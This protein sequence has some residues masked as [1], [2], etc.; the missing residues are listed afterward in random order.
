MS[1]LESFTL[2]FET[3]GL[4]NVSKETKKLK[5]DLNNL[6]T[7]EKSLQE[8]IK[9]GG[10]EA[11]EAKIRL[12]KVQTE[13]KNVKKALKGEKKEIAGTEKAVKKLG[14]TVEKEGIRNV[15]ALAVQLLRSVSPMLFFG[16]A[17]SGAMQFVS[18]AN[19]IA[20][21][22]K[23]AGLSMEE[24]QKKNGDKY[25]IFT[26]DDV[27]IAREYEMTMRDVRMGTKSIGAE[28][29]RMILPSL[30]KL[31][32]VVSQVVDYFTKHATFIKLL[33]LGIAAAITVAAIPA[34]ISMGTALWTALAP[35]IAP[36]L[37]V[38]AV[39]SAIALVI[40][41]LIVWING[42][43][44]AFADLWAEVFGD[45]QQAKKVF[46]DL[47]RTIKELWDT[48]A[49]ILKS[50][51]EFIL[52]FIFTSI[53]Q[54]ISA[55]KDFVNVVKSFKA[56]DILGGFKNIGAGLAKISPAGIVTGGII[57][58]V[59]GSHAD[60]LDYV[61]FDGYVAELHKGERVQTKEEAD[62][63]RNGLVAAQK[64]INFTSNFP[65]NSIPTGAISNAYNN[66]TS[67]TSR[68][69]I[70][71]SGVTIQT[72]ATDAQ[73]IAQDFSSYIKQAMISLDDGM[74]A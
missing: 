12:K 2:L 69:T 49:P 9:K 62:D 46:N 31:T 19:E 64:A 68:P 44:S 10:K 30:L 34:I 39:I 54:S 58:A 25:A 20:E 33:F 5:T 27:K 40:E 29:S 67:N 63:W 65:L 73:G 74:L 52:K 26:R 23:E 72:Q 16:K 60:G 55:W 13:I 66:S 51:G 36:A 42:G 53:K 17:I 57:G 4:D 6:E 61:P 18:E 3:K 35:V 32:K 14:K 47:K 43:E 41:D 21:A 37:A 22:A 56:G 8:T 59:N 28:I 50:I 24:F 48:V 70:N 7:E 11:E 1:L 15:K 38:I 45:A 71:I